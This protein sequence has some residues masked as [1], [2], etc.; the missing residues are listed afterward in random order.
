MKNNF[1][2]VS[3]KF[4]CPIFLSLINTIAFVTYIFDKVNLI[5]FPPYRQSTI[6]IQ[7]GKCEHI[8]NVE[9]ISAYNIV[10][11]ISRLLWRCKKFSTL[12]QEQL[13]YLSISECPIKTG[14]ASTTFQLRC[15]VL[16]INITF[17]SLYYN[18]QS[19]LQCIC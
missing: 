3:L 7:D 13:K 6:L 14:N 9:R 19:F 12:S 16:F 17:F 8:Q 11:F 5:S 1:N 2:N 4:S 10:L 18:N 15:K